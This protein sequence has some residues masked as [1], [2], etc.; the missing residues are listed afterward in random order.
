MPRFLLTILI[1]V[2]VYYGLKY[3][4]RLFFPVIMNRFMNN[5]MEGS[6]NPFN[7]Q[8][9]EIKREGEVTITTKPGSKSKSSKKDGDFVD[10]EEIK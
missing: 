2:G 9:P 7:Q 4:F 3:L 5:M 10:Y 1:I 8:Q 6:Q